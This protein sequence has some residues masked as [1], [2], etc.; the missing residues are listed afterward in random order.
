MEHI[1]KVVEKKNEFKLVKPTRIVS[2]FRDYTLKDLDL[3]NEMG[4]LTQFAK[5]FSGWK[6]VGVPKV[7]P[8]Y[9]SRNVLVLE[10]IDG[11]R[12]K[13]IGTLKNVNRKK[14]A[15]IGY[16]SL[17]YQIFDL[18]LFHADLH[19]G[20]IILKDNKIYLVDFGIVGK[21]TPEQQDLVIRE[22]FY[23][24]NGDMKLAIDTMVKMFEVSD[25]SDV[26]TFKADLEFLEKK[27][28]G[29]NIET[30]KPTEL[31][32]DMISVA[33]KNKV[34]VPSDVV[35][36]LKAFITS[37][38]TALL[39]DPHFNMVEETKP[40]LN[41]LLIKK[42]TSTEIF[43][44]LKLK[45]LDFEK[46]LSESPEKMQ[47]L[48]QNLE[49]GEIKVRINDSSSKMKQAFNQQVILVSL[50]AI[51]FIG[52]AVF[53]SQAQPLFFGKQLSELSLL[54]AFVLNQAIC[55]AWAW[56]Y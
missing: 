32:R 7:Y 44:K 39:L 15:S 41:A 40:H 47:R 24:V 16:K 4:H 29:F 35:L 2:E 12:L 31:F 33:I 46:F 49:D 6:N 9:C 53:F 43:S 50:V 3:S 54:M 51:F 10:Y 36:L 26:E 14:I 19:P 20:N 18:G 42:F 56:H 37:E 55:P 17:F 28:R 5:Y 11:V 52:S 48:L 27:W 8:E 1:A 45:A 21:A 34:S 38:G 23:Y 30:D 22:M 13:N 25:D